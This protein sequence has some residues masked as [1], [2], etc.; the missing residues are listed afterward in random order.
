MKKTAFLL[1]V[2]YMLGAPLV[3]NLAQPSRN[4]QTAKHEP[5]NIEELMQRKQKLAH[6]ILDAL[7]MQDFKRINKNAISLVT[8]SRAAEFQVHKTPLY[9]QYTKEFQESAGKLGQSARDQN[10]E[11]TTRAFA[12]LVASCVRCHDYVREKHGK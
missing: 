12:D 4:E 3:A 2:I 1:V 8:L 6:E 10:G 7:I 5:S 11:V 9:V